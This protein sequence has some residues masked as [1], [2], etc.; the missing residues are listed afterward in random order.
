MPARLIQILLLLFAPVVLFGASSAFAATI[1]TY[2]QDT[3]GPVGS[4]TP[5]YSPL[6]RNF[7]VGDSF[8]VTDVDLGVFVTHSWR[9]HQDHAAIA[10]RDEGP[11]GQW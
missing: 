11:A 9:G 6:V 1:H 5:C 8:N 4:T 2:T 3:D 10:V 7:A